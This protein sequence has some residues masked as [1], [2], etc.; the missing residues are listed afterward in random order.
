MAR[1]HA[2]AGGKAAPTARRRQRGEIM[3]LPSGSLRVRVYAGID[4]LSGKKNFLTETIPAGPAAAK[5]AEKIRTRL[6]NEV[7]EQ[8]NPRTKATV[9][10]LL[11]RYL[12]LLDVEETTR[13]RY[14]QVI[15]THIRPLIGHLPVA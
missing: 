12:E 5:E 9:D 10:Q 7:D 1:L 4:A 11:D 2:M 3:T 8:R 6:I 13:Q 15:R 14:E